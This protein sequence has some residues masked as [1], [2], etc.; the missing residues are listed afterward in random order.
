MVREH[1]NLSLSA[2]TP[3][4]SWREREMYYLNL[5]IGKYAS[6][7]LHIISQR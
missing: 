6:Y 4:L 2:L 7:K 3:A 5:I 1:G